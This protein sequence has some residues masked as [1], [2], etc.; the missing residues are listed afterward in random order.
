[1]DDLAIQAQEDTILP[2]RVPHYFPPQLIVVPLNEEFIQSG[3][4]VMSENNGGALHLS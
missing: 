3:T 4:I 2:K 1:M